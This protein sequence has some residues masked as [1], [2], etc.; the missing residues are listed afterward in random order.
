M[1]RRRIV[2]LVAMREVV[3][4]TRSRTFRIST[5]ITAL[6]VVALVVLPSLFS[7]SGQRHDVVG[8]VGDASLSPQLR[9]SIEALGGPLDA[10][11]A[12][13]VV[14]DVP[15]GEARLRAGTF[16]VLVVPGSELVTKA[17][18]APDA[19]GHLRQLLDGVSSTI[20]TYA[21]LQREGLQPAQVDRALAAP[22]LPERGLEA[23]SSRHRSSA[24][25]ASTGTIIV[26]IFLTLYGAFIMNGIVEEKGARVVEVLLSTVSARE[27]LVG[28]VLGIGLVSSI[29]GLVLVAASF[30]ARALNGQAVGAITPAVVLSSLLWFVLGFGLY[31]WLYACAGALVSR[32]EDAQS[33]AFPLQLPL[34]VGYIVGLSGSLSGPSPALTVLSMVPFT[35]PLTMLVRMATHEAPWWQVVVSVSGTLLTIALTMRIAVTVFSGGILRIGRRVKLREAWRGANG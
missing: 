17:T 13:E 21:A 28:K 8:F 24:A 25:G 20:G 22:G 1:T 11:V 4:R 26:Y 23:P 18:V 30:L 5:A 34:L 10:D 6:L 16:D 3:E 33:L 2:R 35:A 15:T 31:S 12:V 14:Q 32:S 27:L 9:H 29:Q 19:T 7:A